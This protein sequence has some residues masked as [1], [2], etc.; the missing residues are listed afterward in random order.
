MGPIRTSRDGAVAA[1]TSAPWWVHMIERFGAFVAIIAALL[2]LGGWRLPEIGERFAV[3]EVDRMTNAIREVGEIHKQAFA[4]A[5]EERRQL[6]Q[7]LENAAAK[8]EDAANKRTTDAVQRLEAAADIRN[9]K[10][11]EEIKRGK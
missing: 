11:I 4:R 7:D 8:R 3:R 5:S 1:H 2:Y 9:Q 6:L 10:L